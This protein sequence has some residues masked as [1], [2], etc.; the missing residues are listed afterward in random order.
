MRVCVCLFVCV[1]LYVCV[2][3]CVC[4][5]VW[6]IMYK[7]MSAHR[8]CNISAVRRRAREAGVSRKSNLQF[9]C[10]KKNGGTLTLHPLSN[11]VLRILHYTPYFTCVQ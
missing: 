9:V 10:Q 8:L 5:C 7:C 11:I 1:C 6:M 3:G 4:V 2:R